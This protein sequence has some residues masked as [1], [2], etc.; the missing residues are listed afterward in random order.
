ML[1]HPPAAAALLVCASSHWG[2][3][4]VSCKRCCPRGREAESLSRL[5][6]R[7]S[8]HTQQR[9]PHSE[10]VIFEQH[11]VVCSHIL[12]R[13]CVPCDRGPASTIGCRD[14]CGMSDEHR[15]ELQAGSSV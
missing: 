2:R 9:T 12:L 11:T 10:P 14:D 13:A 8:A 4:V 15:R 1:R 3:A 5:V 6:R 7:S